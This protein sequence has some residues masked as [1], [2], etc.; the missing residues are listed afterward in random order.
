[1]FTQ[2]KK[3][4]KKKQKKK[5]VNI[6]FNLDSTVSFLYYIMYFSTLQSI[7][8]PLILGSIFFNL[9]A[10]FDTIQIIGRA[11]FHNFIQGAV[12]V[13]IVW[14]LDLQ[15][16][17]QSVPITTNVVSLNSTQAIQHYVIK[18]VSD[19]FTTGRSFSPLIKLT[20]TI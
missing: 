9:A 1:M 13:V 16:P 4:I 17:M 11:I 18:F 20:A 6:S 3:L 12:M 8:I 5:T 15:L 19:K 2:T 7:G 14:Q 10:Y